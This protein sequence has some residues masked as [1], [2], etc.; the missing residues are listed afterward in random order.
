MKTTQL[1]ALLPD[2]ATY[3]LVVQQGNFTNA[4]NS[5]S[6]TPSAVSKTISRL[7][8]ALEVKLIERTTRNL[9]ITEEGQKVY[10]QAV[11][12]LYAAEQA[13][14]LSSNRHLKPQGSI[15]ISAPE[16]LLSIVLQPLIIEFLK[17]YPQ[18]QIKARAIDGA[19]DIQK[20]GIDVAFRLSKH[21]DEHLVLKELGQTHL[22]LCASKPYLMKNGTP[23]QPSDLVNHNC[24]YLAETE[25]DN[26]WTFHKDDES[27]SV[28]VSGRYAVNQAQL[29]F[30]G[31]KSHLGIGLFH[32]FV[33]EDALEHG[34]VVQVLQ[35]W[36]LT[37]NYHGNILMQYPQT[38]YVPAR[39]RLFIDFITEAL[40]A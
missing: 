15:M 29:R 14:E 32:D 2:L 19:V 11:Q 7:E 31:V 25:H 22:L 13:V 30:E 18:I 6:M 20:Q 33:V 1:V 4:A 37:G 38:K 35:D 23:Q 9:R 8:K 12:M 21:P 10:E 5:L 40:G 3:T 28:N 24:L 26:L 27:Q 17:K 16:A 34:E 36:T 39:L